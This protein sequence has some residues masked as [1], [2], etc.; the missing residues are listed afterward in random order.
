L[1]RGVQ[2]SVARTARIPIGL[3]GELNLLSQSFPLAH[4]LNVMDAEHNPL[5]G[6]PCPIPEVA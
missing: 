5:I 6:V 4:D 3:R 1:F 2:Y